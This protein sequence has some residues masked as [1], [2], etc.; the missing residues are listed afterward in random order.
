[1][2]YVLG[3]LFADGSVT[4]TKTGHYYIAFYSK[5][6]ELLIAIREAMRSNHKVAKRSV[7]SGNVYRLQIGSKEM[8]TD[9]EKYGL[10]KTKVHRMQFPKISYTYLPAFI[11]GFFDGDGNVWVGKGHKDSPK[12]THIIQTI[13]T[14]ASRNFLQGLLQ[15][16]RTYEILGGSIRYLKNKQC[17]RLS[18][19]INDSL[20]LYEIMYNESRT[21]L[22]LPRKRVVFEK[23]V[24]L[25]KLQP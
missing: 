25:R 21:S 6:I 10:T 19:S 7:R 1:M 16:T 20:K 12:P 15:A 13:F 24:E 2:A 23:Y 9:L 22:E 3:F 5:D 11:R 14:S 17:S 4:K 8:V 18:Y